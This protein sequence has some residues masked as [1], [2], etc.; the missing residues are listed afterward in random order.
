MLGKGIG[1]ILRFGY[2]CDITGVSDVEVGL[3]L[4]P[5]IFLFV[6]HTLWLEGDSEIDLI[7]VNQD[8]SFLAR[9]NICAVQLDTFGMR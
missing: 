8:S 6:T 3:G 4:T 9:I 1:N 2:Y 5:F 7:K